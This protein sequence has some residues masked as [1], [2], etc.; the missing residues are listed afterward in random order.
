MASLLVLLIV[1]A[2][3]GQ[4][5]SANGDESLTPPNRFV[6]DAFIDGKKAVDG[7]LIEALSGETV[8]GTTK[9]KMVSDDINYILDA[10]QPS[11]GTTLTFRIGG[12][13]ATET[14]NWQM[15]SVRYSFDLNAYTDAVEP[16]VDP[17]LMFLGEM[18][19]RVE[20]VYGTWTEGCESMVVGR[21]YVN[22]YGFTLAQESNVIITLES[23]DADTYLYLRQGETRSGAFLHENDD[24]QG[25]TSVSHIR[26]T[27]Q[28][29]TYNVEATTYHTGQTGSFIITVSGSPT[30]RPGLP[31]HTCVYNLG[32]LF[33]ARYQE[34]WSYH[35]PSNN[36][37]GHYAHFYTFSLPFQ[38]E[39]GILLES[40]V[41]TFL[42]LMDGAG[43]DG[44]VLAENDDVGVGNTNSAVTV[45]LGTGSYTIEATTYKEGETG[46]FTL[47]VSGLGTAPLM[48]CIVGN[49]LSPGDGCG[50][51]NFTI[52]VDESGELLVR[53]PGDSADLDNFSLVR[54]GDNWTIKE[55][56]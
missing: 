8:V 38:A 21:G 5:A 28:A 20:A 42:Y 51:D 30:N 26:D 1:L 2:V 43:K 47:T 24:H 46:D 41:D 15:G 35:C 4:R 9:V 27:L 44:N 40:E 18:T 34:S 12:Y 11:D 37:Q 25:S 7:T 50:Y 32:Q 33:D 16:P 29:G 53:F 55:L 6:G 14:A 31:L 52:E 22:Y 49:T 3:V 56:P 13:P 36:R 23:Q 17:C 45:P 39:V 48:P 54:Y 19:D 10:A